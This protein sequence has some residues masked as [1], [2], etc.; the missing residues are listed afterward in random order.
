VGKNTLIDNF[1]NHCLGEAC[2]ETSTDKSNRYA[3]LDQKLFH[4]LYG[5]TH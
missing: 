2:F 5:A 4:Y 1:R 3:P